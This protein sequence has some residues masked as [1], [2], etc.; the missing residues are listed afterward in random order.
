MHHLLC[1]SKSHTFIWSFGASWIISVFPKIHQTLAWTTG[2]LTCTG[3]PFTCDTSVY[4]LIQRTFVESGLVWRLAYSTWRS[5]IHQVTTAQPCLTSLLRPSTL[6]LRHWLFTAQPCLTSLLRPSA[7]ALRHWLFTAQ[8]CLT[9]LLRPSALV[10]RHWLFTAQPCLTSLLRPSALVLL[11]WLF[12][13]DHSDSIPSSAAVTDV[14]PL[15]FRSGAGG[16]AEAAA[17]GLCGAEEQGVGAAS[18]GRVAPE[19]SV[20]PGGEELHPQTAADHPACL[21]Y[22]C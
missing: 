7:L 20:L 2:S 18:A 9:S 1:Y 14:Q 12:P 10:L 21:A 5:P 4:S 11:H 8:P 16:G 6:A 19:A 22:P 15:A 3:N 17:G 13:C